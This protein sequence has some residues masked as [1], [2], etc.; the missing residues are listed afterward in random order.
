M[1]SLILVMIFAGVVWMICN[2]FYTLGRKSGIKSQKR[3]GETAATGR[4]KVES[5]VVEKENHRKEDD[6]K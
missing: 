2:F 6:K 1:R 3:K 4:K 5:V